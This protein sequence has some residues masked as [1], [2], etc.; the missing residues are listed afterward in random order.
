MLKIL[1]EIVIARSDLCDKAIFYSLVK[2]SL[3]EKYGAVD[4]YPTSICNENIFDKG[5]SA[6]FHP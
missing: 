2:G 6:T 5:N 4:V 3:L 1:P